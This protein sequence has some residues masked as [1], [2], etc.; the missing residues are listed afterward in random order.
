MKHKKINP[1]MVI[2]V[3]VL[4]CVLGVCI[5][6]GMQRQ[7]NQKDTDTE[8][9]GSEITETGTDTESDTESE[10]ETTTENLQI[11]DTNPE[12][13]ETLV[14]FGVDSRSNQLGKDTRS[15]SI[16]IVQVDHEAGT[17]KVAS[18]YRDCMVH[19][20][21]KG[22]EKITHAH[23]YGGP[24]LALSTVNS[25]FDLNAENYV[26]VNF[27]TMRKLV[28]NIGG[29]E[30]ELTDAE[31]VVMNSERITV[32]GTY[33]LNGSEALT[34][35]RIRKIDTDYKRT[36]RQREVLFKIFEK[37]KTLS[38]GDK[39]ELLE[40][41]LDNI[42]TSYRKDDILELLY[43]LSKYNIQEM[44]AFPEV[45][46]AGNIYGWVEIPWSLVDM[47]AAMHKFLYGVTE[48]T[49]SAKVQEYSGHM[50]QLVDGPTHDKRK[51]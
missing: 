5:L 6:L 23:Q 16:M 25:N 30:I 36:E 45:F 44:T 38:Y 2:F 39:I 28:D 26:T 32:A 37:T 35:S 1:V 27:N 42:N 19:I 34:F 47:N 13:T 50:S 18:V 40:D 49:P 8:T 51:Q 11:P 7:A 20:E 9:Q 43:S 15:D 22:Y 31:A 29:I 14:I 48:Y 41:L 21:G 12:G 46:Y 17:V 4:I 24:E 3:L 10:T 33:L